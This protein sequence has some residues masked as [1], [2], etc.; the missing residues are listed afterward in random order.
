MPNMLLDLRN[1]R[2]AVAAAETGSFRQAAEALALPQPSV[3]RRIQHLER[4]LGFPL[5]ERSRT[6]VRP[7]AAGAAFLEGAVAGALQIDLA[8]QYAF[9]V[10]RGHGGELRVGISSSRTGGLFREVLRRFKT[11][12]PG[13]NISLKED[14]TSKTSHDVGMGIIDVA[15]LIAPDHLPVC[16]ARVLW[17]EA[18][19]AVVDKAHNLTGR[20]VVS[21]DELCDETFILSKAEQGSEIHR[22]MIKRLTEAGHR[23]KI[24]IQDISDA[25]VFDLVATGC[26]ITIA[27]ESSDCRVE[28]VDVIPLAGESEALEASAVWRADNI[29]PAVAH[30][31]EVAVAVG[32]REG[33]P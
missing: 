30:L 28:G 24:D 19:I 8:A 33:Q 18:I 27:N 25:C 14:T 21:W 3:S 4:R 9:A 11:L 6:G 15:F 12:F 2:C 22:R 16:D 23:P 20:Q 31:I 29:N 32:H 7:T 17:R 13:V 26:G 5:F 1:L 10:H